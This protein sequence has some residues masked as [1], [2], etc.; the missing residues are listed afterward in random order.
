MP[1]WQ[2]DDQPPDLALPHFGQLGDDDLE[3][4]VHRQA[5]L[6]VE[7]L[8][9]AP[10]EGCQVVVQQEL[11][12]RLGQEFHGSGFPIK[13]RALICSRTISSASLKS[14]VSGAV[15]SV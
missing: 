7:I 12:L 13:K 9:A 8:E 14:E 3:V 15:G 2:V 6:R 5:G 4:P 1:R 10:G 11:V